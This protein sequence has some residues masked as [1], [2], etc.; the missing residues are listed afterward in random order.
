LL[1]ANLYQALEVPKQV[2]E[3]SMNTYLME[4][5]KRTIYEEEMQKLRDEL[6][7]RKM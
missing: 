3:K 2:F 1:Q 6:R 7:T 5:N 4:P